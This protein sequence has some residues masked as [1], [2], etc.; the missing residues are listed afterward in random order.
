MKEIR[1]TEKEKK[2]RK[3][4]IEKGPG[5]PIWPGIR[6]GPRPSRKQSRIGIPFS[7]LS[8]LTGGTPSSARGLLLPWTGDH[9]G[10]RL[11]PLINSLYC[12]PVSTPACAY[13]K[14]FLSSPFPPSFLSKSCRQAAR[15]ARRSPADPRPF[16]VEFDNA[17]SPRAPSHGPF[18]FPSPSA[19]RHVFPLVNIAEKQAER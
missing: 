6:I 8:S 17:V 4:K 7:L 16:I 2:K 19:S 1:K 9:A 13:I 15:I 5:K 11:L 3:I 10:D 12:P 18:F 14:T